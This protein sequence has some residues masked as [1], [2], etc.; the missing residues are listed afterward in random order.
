MI[1]VKKV[2]EKENGAI[3]ELAS[4]VVILH[5]QQNYIFK[6]LSVIIHKGAFKKVVFDVYGVSCECISKLN[7][8]PLEDI[9][10]KELKLALKELRDNIKKLNG[11]VNDYSQDEELTA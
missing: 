9:N 1:N 6:A 5:H 2:S 8:L 4:E 3:A 10:E 11:I 7:K